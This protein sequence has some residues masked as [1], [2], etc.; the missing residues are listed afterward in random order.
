MLY[1]WNSYDILNQLYLNKK[2]VKMCETF[3]SLGAQE[4]KM[5]KEGLLEGRE[6]KYMAIFS[7]LWDFQVGG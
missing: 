6:N 3:W 5:S 4:M 2:I 1:T 7:P